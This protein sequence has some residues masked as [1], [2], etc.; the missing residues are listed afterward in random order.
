MS[1]NR[2]IRNADGHLVGKLEINDGVLKKFRYAEG[3]VDIPFEVK[4]QIK[5]IDA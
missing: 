3:S 5:D 2:E 1:E 4:L